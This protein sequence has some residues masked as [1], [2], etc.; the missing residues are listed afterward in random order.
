MKKRA[1]CRKLFVF[2][3]GSYARFQSFGIHNSM[4]AE[5]VIEKL[6]GIA[7]EKEAQRSEH[8]RK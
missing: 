5:N 6:Q 1:N 3:V 4:G 8:T 2:I 7:R